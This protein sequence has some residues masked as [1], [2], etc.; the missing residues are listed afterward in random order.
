MQHSDAHR[1][2]WPRRRGAGVSRWSP[3]WVASRH[4]RCSGGTGRRAHQ[5]PKPGPANTLPSA[6]PAKNT[7]SVDNGE[8]DSIAQ[9][10]NTMIIGGTFTSVNSQTRNHV[11]AFDRTTGALSTSFAPDA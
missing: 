6:V 9:N 3:H 4:A 11:A 2:A 5:P 10:G 8:T 1:L 7:P